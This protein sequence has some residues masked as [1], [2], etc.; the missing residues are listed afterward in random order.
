MMANGDSV[1]AIL[2]AHPMPTE[3]LV[4][5]AVTYADAYPR[6]KASL[7]QKGFA[8]FRMKSLLENASKRE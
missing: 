3:G 1:P 8:L 5:A 2:A 4:H 7:A 6:S